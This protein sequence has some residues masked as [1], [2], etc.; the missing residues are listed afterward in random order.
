MWKLW[1]K[2]VYG[3]RLSRGAIMSLD[4]REVIIR[5][6][7][8]MED[9]ISRCQRCSL[10]NQC[11]IKP[12]LGKGEL[13]PD[14]MMVFESDNSLTKD[15][16]RL[17]D[18]RNLIKSELNVDKIYH[19][20]LVRCEPKVC[21][22]RQNLNNFTGSACSYK[23]LLDRDNK[24]LLNSKICS[25]ISVKPSDEEIIFCLPF[26]L[27]E[28]EI[29]NPPNIILFGDRVIDYVAKSF[30]VYETNDNAHFTKKNINFYLAG[31]EEIFDINACNQ[32]KK[33]FMPSTIPN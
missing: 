30:G 18:L 24:C 12:S 6:I 17:I 33:H 9:R 11:V 14:I 31:N 15:S 4:N 7:I 1:L 10:L 19:T 29:L 5:R 21:T 20:F 22:V 13:E 32:L 28:M 26:L 16:R 3:T 8:N 27:E 25:G 23:K 2:T